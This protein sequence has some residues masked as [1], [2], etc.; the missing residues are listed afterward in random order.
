MIE[1]S[2]GSFLIWK[3]VQDGLVDFNGDVIVWKGRNDEGE[4]SSYGLP[5][6]VQISLHWPPV[7][8]SSALNDIAH[9]R[10]R[11][12]DNLPILLFYLGPPY[13]ETS[14]PPR[15]VND[16]SLEKYKEKYNTS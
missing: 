10:L 11:R 14:T 5:L 8:T 3:W 15:Y 16:I 6:K 1:G 2:S 13:Y 4:C 9:R 12:S 7:L